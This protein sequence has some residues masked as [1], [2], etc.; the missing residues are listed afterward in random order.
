LFLSPH[1]QLQN[2]SAQMQN[3]QDVID[4][5]KAALA[6]AVFFSEEHDGKKPARAPQNQP[7]RKSDPGERE[8]EA[9]RKEQRENARLRSRE[10]DARGPVFNGLSPT[11]PARAQHNQ[12]AR[13]SDPGER[14]WEAR[15]KEQRENA[16]LRSR[17]VDARGPVFN[18]LSPAA[19][20]E[21]F[22]GRFSA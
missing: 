16:R 10:V 18:W 7:A 15:R 20:L 1:S 2:C 19:N 14:E 8:W 22:K 13:K 11:A 5:L 21:G 4:S 6:D 3:K 9:R 12:P 17:G